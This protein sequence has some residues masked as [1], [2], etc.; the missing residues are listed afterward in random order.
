MLL[1]LLV[2]PFQHVHPAV[3][4]A[5]DA[6]HD[7]LSVVHI[8]FLSLAETPNQAGGTSVDHSDD[9]HRSRSLDTFATIAQASHTLWL[10][11][12]SF[13]SLEIPAESFVGVDVT[14]ACGHDPP[15]LQFWPSRGPPA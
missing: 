10:E 3:E 9:D 14:E 2:A 8:H 5:D 12:Q 13:V 1:A 4:H 11:L 7:H 6:D 15:A